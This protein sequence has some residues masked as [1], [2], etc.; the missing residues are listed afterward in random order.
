[1]DP[2]LVPLF[3]DA[4]KQRRHMYLVFGVI[5]IAAGV[6]FLLLGVFVPAKTQADVVPKRLMMLVAVA[7]VAGG[8]FYVREAKRYVERMRHAFATP[9]S[10]KE[11]TLVTVIRGPSR[12]YAFHLDVGQKKPLELPV[13]TAG[14]FETMTPLM[15]KHFP[16]AKPG[17]GSAR[18]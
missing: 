17:G 18:A 3:E 1:M 5:F 16:S 14:A 9:Q 12:T 7:F 11:I 15:V 8:A 4:L 13:L 10:V 6:G 2:R